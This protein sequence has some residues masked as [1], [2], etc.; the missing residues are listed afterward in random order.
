[1]LRVP[2]QPRQSVR[3]PRTQIEEVRAGDR[4]L[5]LIVRERFHPDRTHFVTDDSLPMQVG[6][7]VYPQDGEVGAPRPRAAGAIARGDVGGPDRPLGP[8]RDGRLR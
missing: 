6:F 1:M 7:I 2:S 3:E 8:V 5:A 4:L